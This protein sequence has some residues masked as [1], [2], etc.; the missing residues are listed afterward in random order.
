[1]RYLIIGNGVVGITAAQ[2]I[3]KA[4]AE[5]EVHIYDA[6]PYLYYRR[7]QLWKFIADQAEEKALYFR[8]AEW[9]AKQGIT[10]H[11]GT[12][13]TE[14]IP[15][16]HALVLEDG[17]SV[18]YDRLLLAMGSRC[19]VPPINGVDKE[20][21]FTLRS[22]DDAKAIKE[23]A[24][25][26]KSAV[27]IGGGL[28]GLETGR[29]ISELGLS[30]TVLET[31]PYLLPRQLDAA[32]AA[33]LQHCLEDQ[34]FCSVMTDVQ[35]SAILGDEQVT[36]VQLTDGTVVPADL[37]VISTGIRLRAELAD[38]AG[39]NVNRGVLVDDQMNA[40]VPDIFA[41][42]DVAVHNGRIYGII[43][44]ALEQA[45]I[46]AANMVELGSAHY[47]GTLPATSLKITGVSLTCL[48][49]AM[50]EA[51]D[52][53]SILR[54][55]DPQNGLYTRVALQDGKIIGAILLGNQKNAMWFKRLMSMQR[56]IS[57]YSEQLLDPE[58]DIKAL[59]TSQT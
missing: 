4:D 38:Q 39:L 30:V 49:E 36:G 46:A 26:S 43:P 29:A 47:H 42:G 28:L 3:K 58:F 10:L 31:C 55:S 22:L 2:A 35:T 48:G 16:S 32:G 9:Y 53:V 8:P 24:K 5:S 37:V 7:P 25:Q 20:G 11:L 34:G 18:E 54:R 15:Q 57:A 45:K 40:G 21:V 6:E 50:I 27:I 17:S 33:V 44:A 23:R 51:S 52:S 56:D 12:R 41:A 14:I 59:A 19:F 1:M 13:V